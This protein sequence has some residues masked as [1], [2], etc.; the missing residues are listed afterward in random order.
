M[1]PKELGGIFVLI[2]GFKG[3]ARF[4]VLQV[5]RHPCTF[6]LQI[7]LYGIGKSRVGQPV[8][9][10]GLYRQQST[11]HFVLALRTAL[12]ALYA[13]RYAPFEGLVVARFKMQTVHALQGPPITPISHCARVF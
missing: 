12:K 11:G 1:P 2:A 9:A 13:V 8:G 7:A 6:T 10:A 4:K 5:L 3:A